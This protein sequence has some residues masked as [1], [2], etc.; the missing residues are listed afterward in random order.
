MDV[1]ASPALVLV[2]WPFDA[3]CSQEKMSGRASVSEIRLG[4]ILD[5]ERTGSERL[6]LTSRSLR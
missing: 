5:A 3:T 4:C 6:L 1:N 2:I